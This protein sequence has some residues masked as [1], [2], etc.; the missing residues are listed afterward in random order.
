MTFG[1]NAAVQA[2][3]DELA[4][5]DDFAPPPTPASAAAAAA[6]ARRADAERKRIERERRRVAGRPDPRLV[7]GVVVRALAD[8]LKTVDARAYI[9]RKGTLDGLK[10]DAK[11]IFRLAMQE[12]YDRGVDKDVAKATMLARLLPAERD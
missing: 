5:D 3:V 7:D 9:V 1:M 10:L 11:A 4:D 6:A 2:L 12:L 8:A